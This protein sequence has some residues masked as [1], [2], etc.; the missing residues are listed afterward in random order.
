MEEGIYW[1]SSWKKAQGSHFR[2]GWIQSLDSDKS[3]SLRASPDCA[4][5]QGWLCLGGFLYRRLTKV[6]L[7]LQVGIQWRVHSRWLLGSCAHPKTTTAASVG[8]DLS[9]V[10]LAAFGQRGRRV[11]R[12]K[13]GSPKDIGLLSKKGVDPSPHVVQGQHPFR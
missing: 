5:A 10:P 13:R 4:D 12:Q 8:L 6:D 9:P 11:C 3:A 1:F 7:P 2:H